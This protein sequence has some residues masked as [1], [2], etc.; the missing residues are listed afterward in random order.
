[1]K[2]SRPKILLLVFVALCITFVLLILRRNHASLRFPQRPPVDFSDR[3]LAEQARINEAEGIM[4]K[5][6]YI[7]RGQILE[8]VKKNGTI[9]DADLD[10]DIQMLK[11]PGPSQNVTVSSIRRS[12]F[13]EVLPEVKNYT[14]SQ[15]EVVFQTMAIFVMHPNR[16]DKLWSIGVFNHLKDTRAIFYLTPLL[17]DTD[18]VVRRRAARVIKRINSQ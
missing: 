16:T 7:K 18:I 3:P 15:K 8:S 12:Q 4:Y 14:P 2:F 1:M 10:W 9:S 13:F 17:N 6:D 11:S 5:N